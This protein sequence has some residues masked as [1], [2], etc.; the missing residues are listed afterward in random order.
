MARQNKNINYRFL[1]VA[2]LAVVLFLVFGISLSKKAFSKV[3]WSKYPEFPLESYLD[4][5]TLWS[6]TDYV[7]EGTFQNILLQQLTIPHT[8]L[9]YLRSSAGL[10]STIYCAQ[11]FM[12]SFGTDLFYVFVFG[13]ILYTRYS[14][15]KSDKLNKFGGVYMFSDIQRVTRFVLLVFLFVFTK[16]VNNAI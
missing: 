16:D 12:N 7:L 15:E 5:D 9:E 13:A 11:C 14:F 2:G 4:G 8:N 6:N 1:S 3:D 10:G